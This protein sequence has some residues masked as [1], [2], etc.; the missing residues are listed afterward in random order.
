MPEEKENKCPLCDV[1]EDTIEKLKE[2]GK[3]SA[4]SAPAPACAGRP[5]KRKSE[6]NN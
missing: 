1:S 4:S 6:E 5:E 3:K 2:A